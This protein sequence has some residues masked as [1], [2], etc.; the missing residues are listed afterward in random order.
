M[1]QIMQENINEPR[2]IISGIEH[3]IPERWLNITVTSSF[4]V[5]IYEN[6]KLVQEISNLPV[7]SFK[8][9]TLQS[10]CVSLEHVQQHVR[11]LLQLTRIWSPYSIVYIWIFLIISSL[12]IRI[13]NV[14]TIDRNQKD[15]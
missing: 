14:P 15:Y 9:G 8:R 7:K 1:R 6:E 5:G 4:K 13:T 2:I 11:I 10:V 3:T 12:T